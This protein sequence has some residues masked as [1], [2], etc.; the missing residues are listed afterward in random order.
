[1]GILPPV[2]RR[3]GHHR[4]RSS[5]PSS[6]SPSIFGCALGAI[7]IPAFTV[8]QEGTTEESR[9]RIFGGVFTVINASIALPLLAFGGAADLS[10]S[11]DGVVDVFGAL[12][13]SAGA[14]LPVRLLGAGCWSST[15][16][17]AVAAT[18]QGAADSP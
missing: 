1:M 11:V 9:G 12:V 3:V 8:L 14:R 13:V 18:S 15:S 2:F 17:P 10:H 6:S 16:R 4:A 7:L 5:R